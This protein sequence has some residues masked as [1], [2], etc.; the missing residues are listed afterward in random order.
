V[1]TLAVT[2]AVAYLLAATLLPA[3]LPLLTIAAVISACAIV[4]THRRFRGLV[5]TLASIG[6]WLAVGLAPAWLLPDSPRLGLRWIVVFLFVLPLPLI[7]W[8]YSRTFS[9][10]P[11]P[12]SPVPSP[13]HSVPGPRSPVPGPGGGP[14]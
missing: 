1:P 12:R 10:T 7:P 13:R 6:A 2:L 5:V 3:A 14:E 9:S 4:L 11:G 8:L